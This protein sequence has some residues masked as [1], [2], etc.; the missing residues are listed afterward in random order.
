MK[1][2]ILITLCET[3]LQ[4]PWALSATPKY[5]CVLSLVVN[6]AVKDTDTKPTFIAEEAPTL[7][8]KKFEKNYG[9]TGRALVSYDEDTRKASVWMDVL[10]AQTD[11]I[12]R[13]GAT[14]LDAS[15]NGQFR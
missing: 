5:E 6:G 3:L 9:I 12:A 1:G 11:I 8:F 14:D 10:E 13:G 15:P 4:T 7:V 2:T